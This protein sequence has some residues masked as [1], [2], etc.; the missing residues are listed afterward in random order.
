MPKFYEIFSKKIEK[1]ANLE[2]TVPNNR[3]KP[4]VIIDIHEK[5]SLIPSELQ[6]LGC[7]TEFINLGVGDYII[8]NIII[9]RKTVGDFISSMINKRIIKQLQNMQQIEDKLLI[10]EGI[11]EQELY[12]KDSKINENA[13]RGFIL[14]ILFNYKIPVIL[15]KDYNDTVKFLL[16]L[17]K[18][19]PKENSL[20]AKKR[21]ADIN[22]QIQYIL[23]GFPGIGPKNAKK[24]LKEFHTIKEIIN[25]SQENLQ[26]CIGKKAEIFDLTKKEYKE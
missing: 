9:E 18:K 11:D 10:I 6:H 19:Q 12:S 25:A 26:K 13:I 14:S 22:E 16:V 15:T 2:N 8:N 23:E 3:I 24:L 4:K 1:E 7:E 17:A 21:A 5:N 20:N